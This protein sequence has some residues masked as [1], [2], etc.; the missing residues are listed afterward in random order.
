MK[1]KTSALSLTLVLSVFLAYAGP[2]KGSAYEENR[3]ITKE[4]PMKNSGSLKISNEFGKIHFETWN[5]DKVSFA[6]EIMVMDP[7]EKRAKEKAEKI[8]PEFSQSGNRV[9]CE[10]DIPGKI[11][12]NGKTQQVEVNIKVQLP[13]GVSLDVKNSFGDVYL[14]DYSG[15]VQMNVQYGKLHAGDL[16]GPENELKLAF[17]GGSWG[18]I[19]NGDIDISYSEFDMGT[20]DKLLINSQFSQGEIGDVAD[21]QAKVNYGGLEVGKVEKLQGD[22]QFSS[23]EIDRIGQ[24][25][26]IKSFYGD[27]VELKM[28]GKDFTKI[29]IS[30]QFASVEMNFEEGASF[31][32][33]ADMDFGDLDYREGDFMKISKEK[34]EYVPSATYKGI[35]GKKADPSSEVTI[36]G[37]YGSVEI[38]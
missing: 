28:V 6:I 24:E 20:C 16:I 2:K 18:K 12:N 38:N 17:G 36:R 14:P 5:Q 19:V 31:K 30:A 27:G 10:I 35:Y 8:V 26:L 9:I 1:K 13:D 34:D 3:T 4:Y 7:S 32:L 11:N 23:V 15:K 22:F 25:A 37:E 21:L 29:D 33:E